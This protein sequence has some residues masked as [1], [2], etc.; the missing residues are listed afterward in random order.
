MAKNMVQSVKNAVEKEMS[1]DL[2][3]AQV[4]ATKEIAKVKKEFGKALKQAEQYV[5]KNPEKATAIAAGIGATVGAG[6]TALIAR[7]LR[8]K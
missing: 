1:K 7:H 3:K 5:K 6:I 8:K 4:L 2:K